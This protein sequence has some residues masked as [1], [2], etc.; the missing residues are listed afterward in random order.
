MC[1]LDDCTV[2]SLVLVGKQKPDAIVF[3]LLL[4]IGKNVY[5]L[6]FSTCGN[7]DL[8]VKDEDDCSGLYLRDERC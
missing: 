5:V 3:R 1:G 6:G 4:L 2:S 7:V 8:I